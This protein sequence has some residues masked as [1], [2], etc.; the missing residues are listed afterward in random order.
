MGATTPEQKRLAAFQKA[1][2]WAGMCDWFETLT[3]RQRGLHLTEWLQGLNKA[4][5]WTRLLEITEAAIPQLE[6]KR[7]PRISLERILRAQALSRLD[8]PRE[9]MEAHREN[10]DL[11]YPDGYKNAAQEALT[12]QDWPALERIAKLRLGPSPQD[13]EALAHQAL[14][15][16]R[17]DRFKEA[18]PLL[19]GA[20]ERTPG[21]ADLWLQLGRILLMHRKDL[22][23]SEQAFDRCLAL[24]PRHV[25]ALN[26]RGAAWMS[27]ARYAEARQDFLAAQ[28][29]APAD[30]AIQANIQMADRYLEAHARAARKAP[31]K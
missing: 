2:D 18:E 19:R 3:P 30:P 20:T 5:R 28:A 9:A 7:G 1:G 15:V 21:R 17:Q 11:G 29:L 24:D 16:A 13:E 6:A 22:A 10:G 8:R 25:E 14:A 26:F 27:Q 12:L 4:Q 31:R 23:A